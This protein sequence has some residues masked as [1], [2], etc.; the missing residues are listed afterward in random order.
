MNL[1]VLLTVVPVPVS[2]REETCNIALINSR[3]EKGKDTNIALYFFKTKYVMPPF[4]YEA[5]VNYYLQAE[6]YI[7]C[8][9]RLCYQYPHALP[10]GRAGN[11]W[12][13][14]DGPA[15]FSITVLAVNVIHV[16]SRKLSSKHL[17]R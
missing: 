8:C 3:S 2:A 1:S 15:E 4:F 10:V 12:I 11:R 16:T 5:S 9:R 13:K 7:F 6:I 17:S 14:A